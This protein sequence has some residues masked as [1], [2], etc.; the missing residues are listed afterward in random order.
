MKATTEILKD[1]AHLTI[2]LLVILI[3]MATFAETC[4][5]QQ[6]SNG[7]EPNV[8]CDTLTIHD[9]IRITE[10]TPDSTAVLGFKKA[11]LPVVPMEKPNEI[12]DTTSGTKAIP[13]SATVILPIEQRHYADP[14]YEAWIS[15]YDAKLDSLNLYQ[16]SRVITITKEVEKKT[17]RWGISAGA[18]VVAT[19]ERIEP[20]IFIGVSYTFISF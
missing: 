5:R 20:G 8:R 14:K 12:P 6:G 3:G 18:G 19:P 10:P 17:K 9:T 2:A 13:D 15:G 16:T 1:V 4:N 7:K 11:T